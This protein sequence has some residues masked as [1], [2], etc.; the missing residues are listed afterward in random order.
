MSLEPGS[1]VGAYEIVAPLGAGGM[2]SVYRARDTRLGRQVAIKVVADELATDRT[3]VAR[4]GREARLTSSLNHPGIVTVYDVGEFEGRPYIVMELVDGQ[5]LHTR[6]LAGSLPIRQAVA[7]ASH[8]ADG[9]AAAHAAGAVHRDLTPRN[10]MLTGTGQ[11]KIVDFGLGK[12]A[13]VVAGADE[14]T[15]QRDI[16]DTHAIV[17]TAGYMSPEQVSRHAVDFRADQFALGAILYEM[18]SG[19]RA[20]KRE[21]ALQTMVSIVES[22]PQPLPELAPDAPVELHTIVSRCL[23]KEPAG[24]YASTQDLARDL[25]DVEVLLAPGSR[26]AP[27]HRSRG[28]QQAGR[29]LAPWGIAAALLLLVA[30]ASTWAWFQRPPGELERSRT[31]LNRYD[32][33]ENV[34]QAI[35]LLTAFAAANP[36]NATA[37]AMLAEAYW[38]SYDHSKD[39]AFIDKA[40]Q[41]A[42]T[43]LKLDEKLPHTHVALALINTGQGRFD[44]AVVEANRAIALDGR[45]AAAFRELG[46]AQQN[47]KLIEDAERSYRKAV[48]LDP[49]DWSALNQLGGVLLITKRAAESIPSFRRALDIAPDNVRALNNLGSAYN[50]TGK[51]DEAIATYERSLSIAAN[52]TAAQNLGTIYYTRGAYADAARAYQASVS[53]P[54]AT[55]GHWRNLGSASYWVPGLRDQSKAA[56]EKAVELG[57][58]ARA[59]NPRD[60]AVTTALADSYAVLSR[61][62]DDNRAPV[63]RDK[64]RGTALE[65]S[66]LALQDPGHIYTLAGAYEQMGDRDQALA[67]LQKA[68]KGGYDVESIK[69]SPWMKDIRTDARFEQVVSPRKPQTQEP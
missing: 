30:A 29:S 52:A 6:L 13:P 9:L 67:W 24:R 57:E 16:T 11:P 51:T 33:V 68:I 44:G 54:G 42:R 56:Y 18:V 26:S 23:C 8:V 32:V 48:D 37:H 62:T 43:A 21:T 38:R 59:T 28:M 19:R 27:S 35:T 64:A 14:P 3:A 63:W 15:S 17:G 31:L 60:V 58:R 34:N 61:F 20:F 36:D 12:A 49:N 25:H 55:V 45:Y 22:E 40:S 65:A 41:A 46:R 10:I 7:I 47:Q 69:T 66:R 2:G 1:K 39:K 50:F 4:M 5:S 53:L